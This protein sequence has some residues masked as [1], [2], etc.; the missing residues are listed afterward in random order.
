MITK[1]SCTHSAGFGTYYSFDAAHLVTFSHSLLL[2]PLFY[3]SCPL[4]VMLQ[5]QL[6]INKFIG[7]DEQRTNPLLGDNRGLEALRLA[8][9]PSPAGPCWN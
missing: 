8:G 7:P 9:R 1:L 3:L 4:N 2:A 6:H 5:R